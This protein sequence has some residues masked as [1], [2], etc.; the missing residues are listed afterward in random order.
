MHPELSLTA[1][2]EPRAQASQRH[3]TTRS[4]ERTVGLDRHQAPGRV[5]VCGA[6]QR[7]S[8]RPGQRRSLLDG[9]ATQTGVAIRNPHR[10]S[11]SAVEPSRTDSDSG[12]P[13][14]CSRCSVQPGLPEAGAGVRTAL[15]PDRDRTMRLNRFRLIPPFSCA[16]HLI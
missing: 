4:Q 6:G 11:R 5:C 9:A 1:P 2:R 16:P 10:R 8:T 14:V 13:P 7:C 15:G 12:V 3:V